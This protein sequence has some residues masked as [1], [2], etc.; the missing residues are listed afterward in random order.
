[1]VQLE[2]DQYIYNVKINT[3]AANIASYVDDNYGAAGQ[4]MVRSD[5]YPVA[6]PASL[7]LGLVNDGVNS[8]TFDFGNI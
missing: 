1:M 7:D 5:A 8:A 4:I 3:G 6:P 2:R